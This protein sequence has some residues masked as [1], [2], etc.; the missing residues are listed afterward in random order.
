MRLS[1]GPGGLVHGGLRIGLQPHRVR[2]LLQLQADR[3]DHLRFHKFVR[4]GPPVHEHRRHAAAMLPAS[5]LWHPCTC[6]PFVNLIHHLRSVRPP[7]SYE[8]G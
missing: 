2:S 6:I 7:H 1:A 5:R 4:E 3:M 8:H